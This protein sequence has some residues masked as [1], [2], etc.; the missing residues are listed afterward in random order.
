ME[1]KMLKHPLANVVVKGNPK[2]HKI[3]INV[4]GALGKS[5]ISIYGLMLEKEQLKFYVKEI[6][7][8]RTLKILDRVSRGDIQFYVRKGVGMITISGGER[9]HSIDVDVLLAPVRSKVKMFDVIRSDNSVQLFLELKYRGFVFHQ[10]V[11]K[12]TNGFRVSKA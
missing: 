10:I 4:L 3:L 6:E 8:D 11:K 9:G 2:S 5:G 12:V 7:C 1:L